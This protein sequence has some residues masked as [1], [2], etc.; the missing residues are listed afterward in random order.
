MDIGKVIKRETREVPVPDWVPVRRT[1]QP[2]PATE[3]P[4]RHPKP[5]EPE[6]V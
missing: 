5:A 3:P 4:V 1:P 6:K 2:D